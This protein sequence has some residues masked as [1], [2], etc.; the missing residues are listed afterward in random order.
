MELLQQHQW[1]RAV[2]A[3]KEALEINPKQP[4]ASANLALLYYQLGR[5]AEGIAQCE[6]NIRL[7]IA[8]AISY[9]VLGQLREKQGDIAAAREA[10][11]QS[12]QLD[13][14]NQVT[15]Q[16]LTNLKAQPR[17]LDVPTK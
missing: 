7:G 10:Y 13:P 12:L 4:V 14:Q 3:F 9:G 16:L 5:Q 2:E 15:Q 17:A 8:P 6:R 1:A 11:E